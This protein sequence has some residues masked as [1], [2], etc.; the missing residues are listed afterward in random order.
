MSNVKERQTETNF[1]ARSLELKL[2]MRHIIADPITA[3]QASTELPRKGSFQVGWGRSCWSLLPPSPTFRELSPSRHLV[4]K[5]DLSFPAVRVSNCAAAYYSSPLRLTLLMTLCPP[6][7]LHVCLMVYQQ[8][9][10]LETTHVLDKTAQW[11][12]TLPRG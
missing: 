5:S 4:L 2:A 1:Q 9:M 11:F 8:P 7:S 3:N 10:S 12:R 6:E